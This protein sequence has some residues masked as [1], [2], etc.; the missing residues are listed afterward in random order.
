MDP[1]PQ[2]TKWQLIL[3]SDSPLV[4]LKY[5]LMS[6]FIMDKVKILRQKNHDDR[7]TEVVCNLH[8]ES[9][10]MLQDD[11]IEEASK[12]KNYNYKEWRR[13]PNIK[14]EKVKF[15]L[16]KKIPLIYLED[17]LKKQLAGPPQFKPWDLIQWI[18][19]KPYKV[20]YGF[21]NKIYNVSR[22]KRKL[23]KDNKTKHIMVILV[24]IEK[25][26]PVWNSWRSY[27]LYNTSEHP[28]ILKYRYCTLST[29]KCKKIGHMNKYD[30]NYGINKYKSIIGRL[31][32]RKKW[33]DERFTD[34]SPP[35]YFYEI[36][37][38]KPFP[39]NT[40]MWKY[41]C[42]VD[43]EKW[44]KVLGELNLIVAYDNECSNKVC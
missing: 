5:G 22:D 13:R 39:W 38:I 24:N 44:K 35:P 2:E 16:E 31:K 28:P 15:M 8:L 6:E 10:D 32:F 25:D 29:W 33:Y 20:H 34:K 42:K 3:P 17:A 21:V 26:V 9:I 11:I 14:R 19:S 30:Y 18:T 12:L 40:F 27:W 4:Y 7:V 36:P 41:L 43:K 23:C 37:F 1:Y